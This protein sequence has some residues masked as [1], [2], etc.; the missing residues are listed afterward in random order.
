MGGSWLEEILEEHVYSKGPFRIMSQGRKF[1]QK[2]IGNMH[3]LG[4]IIYNRLDVAIL[5]YFNKE[6]KNY[7]TKFSFL[8][9]V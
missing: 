1:K 7:V 2:H 3:V 9:L 6:K 4:N 8:K 5:F